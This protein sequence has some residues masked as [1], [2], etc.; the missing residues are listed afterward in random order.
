VI[1]GAAG[2]VRELSLTRDNGFTFN[3][4]SPR[5]CGCFVSYIQAYD[6]Q[7]R[8]IEKQAYGPNAR[9]CRRR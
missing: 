5:G 8:R 2:V 4:P 6:K 1:V 7:G 9:N 3:C